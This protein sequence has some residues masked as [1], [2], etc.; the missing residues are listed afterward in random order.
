VVE[1]QYPE[2]IVRSGPWLID[3]DQLAEF[4]SLVGREFSRLET[5]A[6]ES[7]DEAVRSEGE[8]WITS[9][10]AQR[11]QLGKAAYTEGEIERDRAQKEILIRR[12]IARKYKTERSIEVYL[13]GEKVLSGKTFNEI[14]VHPE[15][16]DDLVIGFYAK[17]ESAGTN[18]TLL[19]LGESGV[20]ELSAYHL[21]PEAA[22]LYGTLRSWVHRV[23]PPRWQ[24]AWF[25]MARTFLI[26]PI[27]LLLVL[28]GALV[29]LTPQS[30]YR[31]EA[32]SLLAGGL[33]TPDKQ[34]KALELLLAISSNNR[35][36]G[37]SIPSWFSFSVVA[38]FAVCGLPPDA[39]QIISRV[40]RCYGPLRAVALPVF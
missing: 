19:L 31:I 40:G 1:L 22:L 15:V 39:R 35:L 13:K 4:D 18:I 34:R 5:I 2:T 17:F 27:F 7:L 8:E 23:G 3:A 24:R 9:R 11:E 25:E 29:S 38:G 21:S 36:T 37:I 10:I 16:L 26:W 20:M 32:H 12:R 6:K 30:P 33:T 14:A 28:A